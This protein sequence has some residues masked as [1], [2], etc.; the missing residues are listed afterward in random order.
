[1]C[2]RYQKMEALQMHFQCCSCCCC[3]CCQVDFMQAGVIEFK[4]RPG[5]PVLAVEHLIEG[6][7]VKYNSNRCGCAGK[8]VLY[9]RHKRRL[10]CIPA[11]C[12]CCGCTATAYTVASIVRAGKRSSTS[13]A[14]RAKH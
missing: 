8:P 9:A 14:A 13:A 4:D 6:D 7:Y 11:K 10:S 3:C 5:K 2:V 1:M 12:K